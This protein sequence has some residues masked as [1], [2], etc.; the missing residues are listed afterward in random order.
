MYWVL[1]KYGGISSI[2]SEEHAAELAPK[3]PDSIYFYADLVNEPHQPTE[4]EMTWLVQNA[5]YAA[6]AVAIGFVGTKA[7]KTRTVIHRALEALFANRC[8]QVSDDWP[9]YFVPDPPYD[10]NKIFGG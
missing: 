1:G 5:C 8:I 7:A 2:R 6:D 4:D 10:L 9:E 3:Y